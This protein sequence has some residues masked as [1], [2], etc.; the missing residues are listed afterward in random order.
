MFTEDLAEFLDT[1]QGFAVQALYNASQ[2]VTGIF[3]KDYFPAPGQLADIESAQPRFACKAA[4]LP[5]VVQGDTLEVESITY[6]IAEVQPD[7]TGW[8]RLV[9]TKQ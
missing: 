1:E 8:L 7:G 5:D 4:D 9:L 3:A 2:P 6:K